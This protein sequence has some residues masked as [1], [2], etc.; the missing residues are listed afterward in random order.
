MIKWPEIQYRK[1]EDG[2]L[3][4]DID[5]PKQPA[6]DIGK[7]GSMR[8]DYLEK[9][10]PA[11]Y[12]MMILEGTLKQH[13]IDVNE[14]AHEMLEQLIDGMKKSE[15]VTEP[16]KSQNQLEWVRRMNSIK[17]RAEEIIITELIYV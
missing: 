10:R 1:A 3:Y 12:Q 5:F 11:A 16:L 13:L 4:P 9:H 2:M 14:Q 17:H 6:G 15:N 8:R 7:Y